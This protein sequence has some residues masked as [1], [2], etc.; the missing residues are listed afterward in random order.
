MPPMLESP[1]RPFHDSEE[2]NMMRAQ[3]PGPLKTHRHVLTGLDV[4]GR[5]RTVILWLES[6]LAC[7]QVQ[8][9]VVITLD[10]TPYT[11][12]ILTPRQAAELA[13]ALAAAAGIP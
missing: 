13:K 7:G 10:A 5:N 1:V 4:D 6:D 8:H 11:A 3:S 12:V 2:E 9:H